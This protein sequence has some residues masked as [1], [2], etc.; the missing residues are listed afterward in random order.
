MQALH[1]EGEPLTDVVDGGAHTLFAK[2]QTGCTS[3]QPL[4]TS[5]AHRLLR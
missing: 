5:T 1:A 2:P 3:V 4:A